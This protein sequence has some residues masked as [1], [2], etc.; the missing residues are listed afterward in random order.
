[1]ARSK[2]QLRADFASA[3]SSMYRHEVPQYGLLLDLVADINQDV[4]QRH[5]LKL[6]SRIDVER[7][8]AIR[9][10]TAAELHSIR[11]LFA[12]M[13]MHP[14]NYYDLSV[15]GLPVHATCFRPVDRQALSDNPFR[16]FTS[17]LRL[18]F[19]ED[20]ALRAKAEAI[21]NQRK[22]FSDRCLELVEQLETCGETF[23]SSLAAEFISEAL[24]IFRW[25]HTSTVDLE[26]YQALNRDHPLVADVVCF[27]GP[28]VNHLT[29]RVLDIEA[30][31]TK[32]LER[33]LQAKDQ[34]EGPPSRSYPILLR[35]TSFL[36]LEEEITFSNGAETGGRHK[37]RFGEIEQRGMALTEK[38]MKL[39]DSLMSQALEL[40]GQ[41]P[42][43]E[44]LKTTFSRF[45][46]EL[47]VLRRE[48]LAYF[49]YSVGASTPTTAKTDGADIT[50]DANIDAL[51]QSGTIKLS[52]ITYEDFLPISAAGIFHSNI[53]DDG[54]ATA[55][56]RS[57]KAAFES[58]L[59][60]KVKSSYEL[61]ECIQAESITECLRQ[62]YGERARIDVGYATTR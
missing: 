31:Q 28:H 46:D 30:A 48:R 34:I 23:D 9:L 16:V 11:R 33:G 17:L 26:T 61:Y 60:M 52:P 44:A 13:D 6:H 56:A 40:K 15:A 3:L 41:M 2:T 51:V 27:R 36:A 20:D 8:G 25:H 39:Y 57:D 19:I 10:G 38:G 12:V 43:E 4:A 32:M 1:M 5:G 24:E 35:Q 42:A 18:D 50:S 58:A 53:G 22:I 7:H 21:L 49:T 59:G 37:A 62:L 47:D 55:Q 29:P 14:V 45:P 54:P